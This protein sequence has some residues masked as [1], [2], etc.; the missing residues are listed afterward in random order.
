MIATG[1]TA[2]DFALPDQYGTIVRLGDYRGRYVLLIFY[3]GD[4]TMVCTKQLC[5]Y[6]DNWEEFSQRNIT[7][8]GINPASVES[9]RQFAERYDFPFPLLADEQ[10]TV[11]KLYGAV[12]FLGLTKR[13]Y[14]LVDPAGTVAYSAGELTTLT[15]RST[16]KLVSIIDALRGHAS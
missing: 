3:P 10:R 14:V 12:S 7:L 13:A 15:R 8:F 11:G 1:A 16:F 6:R 5:N 4:N 9:H 2:P